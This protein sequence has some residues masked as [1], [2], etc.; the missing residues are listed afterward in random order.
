[1]IT[2][3]L[4]AGTVSGLVLGLY[5]WAA[6]EI[7]GLKV[8]TLLMNVDFVPLLQGIEWPWF[9]EW[10]FHMSIAW[11]IG[12]VYAY[13]LAKMSEN[14][15]ITRWVTAGGLAFL[16]ALSYI[17]LTLLAVKQTPSLTSGAAV[18]LWLIGHLL[19]AGSLRLAC[20]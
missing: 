17:P 5:M 10:L 15:T 11:T 18:F 13:L 16:A 20:R 6:E 2:K 8:Y 14:K 1:M 4:W 9:M 12:I 7:T 3:G 19:Y